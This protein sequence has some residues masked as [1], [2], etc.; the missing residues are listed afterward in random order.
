M[1]KWDEIHGV[2][3]KNG[4]IRENYDRLT[5]TLPKD[6]KEKYKYTASL[7]GMKLNTVIKELLE[8]WYNKSKDED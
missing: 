4:Y 1:G 8:D 5:I 2:E 3:Y 7:Y 6:T